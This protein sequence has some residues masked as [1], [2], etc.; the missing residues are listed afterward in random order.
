MEDSILKALK[1]GKPKSKPLNCVIKRDKTMVAAKGTEAIQVFSSQFLIYLEPQTAFKPS[2][3]STA[4]TE[5]S[6]Y[7]IFDKLTKLTLSEKG[8]V[9]YCSSIFYRNGRFDAY[10]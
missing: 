5:A 3:A 7:T 6:T 2:L 10:F 4:A 8:M 9:P 1:K